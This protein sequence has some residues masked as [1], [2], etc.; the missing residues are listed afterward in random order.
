MVFTRSRFFRSHGSSSLLRALFRCFSI[1]ALQRSLLPRFMDGVFRPFSVLCMTLNC[2]TTVGHHL[3]IYVLTYHLAC[4]LT[5]IL[6]SILTPILPCICY[7]AG[8]LA[9]DEIG[10][11]TSS[12]GRLDSFKRLTQRRSHGDFHL[13]IPGVRQLCA[14]HPWYLPALCLV[15][16]QVFYSLQSSIDVKP[17]SKIVVPRFPQYLHDRANYH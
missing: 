5:S 9:G 10:L 17:V 1:V 11:C 8:H 12:W 2:S 13:S 14:F 4:P 3:C 16:T 7:M 15:L 6:P